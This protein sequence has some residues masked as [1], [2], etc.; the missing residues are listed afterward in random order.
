MKVVVAQK[1]SR[2]H[3]L[4]ARALH[5]RGMLAQLVVDWYPPFGSLAPQLA[6]AGPRWLARAFGPWC[7]ELPADLIT[8]MRL[9]GLMARRLEAAAQRRGAMHEAYLRTD[10]AFA[11]GVA[12]RRLPPHDAFFAYAYA[13]L[14]ALHAE[15]ERGVLTVLDQIDPGLP[16]QRLV[17]AEAAAWSAYALPQPMVPAAYHARLR[18]EWAAADVIVVNSEWTQRLL[19]E[20]G[21]PAAKLEVLP[22]AYEA[23]DSAPRRVPSA[24]GE[25]L[26]VLWL[27]SVSLRK[28]IPYLVEAARALEDAPVRFLV[29][30]PL[31]IRREALEQ[32]PGNMEWLGPV[33]ASRAAA[34]YREADVFVLPTVSDGFAL[35]QLEALAHGLPV[36][37][38]PHCARVVE[39]GRSG[40]VVPAR[41]PKALAAALMTFVRDRGLAAR[42]SPACVARAAAFSIDRYAAQLADILE[43]RAH[44]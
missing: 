3:F 33:P 25:P 21:A 6:A 31:H 24:A 2:E 23:G 11:R 30:G 37:V 26:R 41:D 5:R 19:I 29:A 43:R 15:R 8:A 9:R 28:G 39:D 18:E 7:P 27:G 17:E 32:A 4:A 36:V 34:L 12:S 22:L 14:E 20:D 38:T 40:F 13:A 44:G 16:E 35:T 1:G 10:A 42:L